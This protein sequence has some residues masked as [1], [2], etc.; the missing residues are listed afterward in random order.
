MSRKSKKRMAK[1]KTITNE[2][3]SSVNGR[4]V[5]VSYLGLVLIEEMKKEG[6]IK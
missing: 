3:D 1:K 2:Y 6:L 5:K 4:D